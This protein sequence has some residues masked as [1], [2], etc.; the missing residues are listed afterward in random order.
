MDEALTP[1]TVLVRLKGR[2]VAQFATVYKKHECRT[3]SRK[4][5]F[6]HMLTTVKAMRYKDDALP[7]SQWPAETFFSRS[8]VCTA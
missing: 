2:E 3:Y 1:L 6:A 7:L 8:L 5:H 4:D